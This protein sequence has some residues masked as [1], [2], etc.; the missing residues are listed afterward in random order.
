[1]DLSIIARQATIYA[2]EKYQVSD[3]LNGFSSASIIDAVAGQLVQ[4]L[5]PKHSV[6]AQV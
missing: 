4:K 3:R 2:P 5:E 1:M 6:H